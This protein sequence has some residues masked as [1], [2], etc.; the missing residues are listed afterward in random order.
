MCAG[1]CDR[2]KA[3]GVHY[4]MCISFQPISW[5]PQSL[6]PEFTWHSEPP[7]LSSIR[8]PLT[9]ITCWGK[10]VR[11]FT[12]QDLC[13]IHHHYWSTSKGTGLMNWMLGEHCT[14]THLL[15]HLQIIST[16]NTTAAHVS[17][18]NKMCFFSI[19]VSCF[20]F[21]PIP[22][23]F[24]PIRCCRTVELCALFCRLH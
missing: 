11:G 2:H 10:V 3:F 6:H 7:E 4:H 15:L 14:R 12:F 23:L 5:S 19:V 22:F 1:K 17:T 9:T 16:G 24:F 13:L 8:S 18:E 20:S 21:L